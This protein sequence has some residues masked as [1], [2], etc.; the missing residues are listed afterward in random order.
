M[1][2]FFNRDPARKLQ[3]QYESKLL[4]AMEA[5]RAGDIETYSFLTAEAEA[6]RQEIEEIES[7]A[8]A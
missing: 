5:Q 3:K 8:R 1:F 2:S 6:L 7:T 4:E